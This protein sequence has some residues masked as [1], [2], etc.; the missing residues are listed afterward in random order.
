MKSLSLFLLSCLFLS[1]GMNA[2]N[3][4]PQKVKE[5]DKIVQ[6]V[7]DRK[8]TT[9]DYMYYDEQLTLMKF[10]V[11]KDAAGN[12]IGFRYL[13]KEEPEHQFATYYLNNEG[14][15]CMIDLTEMKPGYW[16]DEWIE[17]FYMEDHKP[18][19]YTMRHNYQDYV[20]GEAGMMW[21]TCWK[22]ASRKRIF[23]GWK[24]FQS[25]PVPY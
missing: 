16:N 22:D 15:V 4:I 18:F 10:S 1:S 24:I 21:N 9:V 19:Y 8:E 11:F 13:L 23:F 25:M 17:K 6:A 12:I 5:I 3:D 20:P 7:I 2:Q 14:I